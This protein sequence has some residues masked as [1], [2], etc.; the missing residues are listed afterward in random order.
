[1][2]LQMFQYF[3]LLVNNKKKLI[4]NSPMIEAYHIKTMSLINKYKRSRTQFKVALIFKNIQIS[5]FLGDKG[6]SFL[7]NKQLISLSLSLVWRA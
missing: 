2:L 5:I 6:N 1:M 7:S 4:I 3:Y